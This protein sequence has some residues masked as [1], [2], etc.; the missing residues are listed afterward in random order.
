MTQDEAFFAQVESLS[1]TSRL[2][3]E[4]A[5]QYCEMIQDPEL[6]KKAERL[7]EL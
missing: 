4:E 2:A 1:S 5:C 7:L 3:Y 6:K